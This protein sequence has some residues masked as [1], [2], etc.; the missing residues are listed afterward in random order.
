M[1]ASIRCT[2]FAVCLTKRFSPLFP[3]SKIVKQAKK[4]A[5]VYTTRISVMRCFHFKIKT[6]KMHRFV[7]FSFSPILKTKRLRRRP[8]NLSFFVYLSRAKQNFSL[9][10][11]ITLK[12]T[13]SS[14]NRLEKRNNF[15]HVS[16]L[17]I[18]NMQCHS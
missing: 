17:F 11:A 4:Q 9:Y 1:Y 10:V 14:F 6:T 5:Y 18:E 15:L 7:S 13:I 8:L 12:S 2:F 3:I 16:H